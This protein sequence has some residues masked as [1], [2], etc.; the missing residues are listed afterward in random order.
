MSGN[1]EPLSGELALNL[2]SGD[3]GAF[4]AVASMAVDSYFGSQVY[5]SSC[6]EPSFSATSLA[7]NVSLSPVCS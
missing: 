3:G 6:S 2:L 5:I 1:W 7:V 4:G